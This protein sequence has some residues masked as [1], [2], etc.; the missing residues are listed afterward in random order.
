MDRE[1]IEDI[2]KDITPIQTTSK[3]PDTSKTE[4]EGTEGVFAPG[5]GLIEA[6][7]AV[8]ALLGLARLRT[9]R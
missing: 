6:V 9:R 1:I 4:T 2:C 3:E 8:L 7:F 5:F